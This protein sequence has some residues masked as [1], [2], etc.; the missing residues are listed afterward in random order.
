MIQPLCLLDRWI[1]ENNELASSYKQDGQDAQN[2]DHNLFRQRRYSSDFHKLLKKIQGIPPHLDHAQLELSVAYNTCVCFTAQ[3]QFEDAQMLLTQ[4]IQR[5]LEIAGEN[6][7]TSDPSVLWKAALKSVASTALKRSV[8]GLFCLQW[9][10][11]L[12]KSCW[13]AIKEF[14]AKIS[15]FD[16]Q[17]QG[18]WDEKIPNFPRLVVEPRRLSEL[19]KI[20]S[21]ISQGAERLDEGWST[22]SSLQ[23]ASALPAPRALI[24]YTHLLSGSCLAHMSR[25]QMALQCFRKALE[26]DP[27]CVCALYQSILIYRQL[28]NSQAE[29]QAL[30]ILHSTLLLPSTTEQAMAGSQLLSPSLFLCSKSLSS[31][32]SVPSALSVLHCLALKC[33]I[34]GRVSEGVEYYLDLLAALHSEDQHGPPAAVSILPKLPRLYLEAGAALLMAR[35]PADCLTLCDEVSRTTVDLLPEKVIVDDPEEGSVSWSREG[36]DETESGLERLLWAAASYLLQGHCYCQLM[37]WKQAVTN[38]TRCINLV[39]K[40]HYKRRSI[41][42]QIPSTDI[43]AEQAGDLLVLQRLKGLSLAGRGISF[44]QMSQLR[45]A[46]RDLQLSLQAHPGV[47]AG[48]WCGEVLWRLDRKQEAAAYWKKTWSQPIPF[49]AETLPVYAQELQYDLLLDSEELHQ[50]LQELDPI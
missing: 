44:A 29:I 4:T 22:L 37:E 32:L 39:V 20:C 28:G 45:E 26:T 50:R 46:L 35:R 24:A 49:I 12:A 13:T 34:H 8:L 40:V 2:R 7:G 3:S 41:S 42:P 15:L 16:E 11:W 6:P 48:Q 18:V 19:L 25:P 27:C 1:Q 36:K 47:T 43:D 38:Y 21:A 17:R 23:A 33:V 14:Q 10:T 30:R 9:G 31:L 5:V